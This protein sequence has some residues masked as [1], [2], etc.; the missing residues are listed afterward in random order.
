MT[1]NHATLDPYTNGGYDDDAT[2][3]LGITSSSDQW[4]HFAMTWDGTAVRTFVNGVEKLTKTGD[5]GS[6]TLNTDRSA[7][8][9]GGY[10]QD[11]NYF[12]GLIDEFRVWNVAHTATEITATMNK[13]LVGNE[14]GLVLYLKFDDST[15]SD[16]VT[17]SGHTAHNGALMSANGMLPTFVTSTAPISCP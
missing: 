1:G 16:S 5:S 12:N 6:T 9:I 10:E 2:T 3:Y 8:A 15:A 17:T 14:T 11:G 13:T 4:V 7:I